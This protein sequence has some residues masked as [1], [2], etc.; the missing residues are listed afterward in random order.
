MAPPVLALHRSLPVAASTPYSFP[1]LLPT[2][3]PPLHLHAR[4]VALLGQVAEAARAGRSARVVVKVNAL[5]DPGLMDALVQAASAGA[6]GS[7]DTADED[8]VQSAF[9]TQ[10]RARYSRSVA[11]ISPTTRRPAS[12]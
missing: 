9:P 3:T 7:I 2:T 1:L 11:P 5:T 12:T 6:T 4:F 8:G 10:D